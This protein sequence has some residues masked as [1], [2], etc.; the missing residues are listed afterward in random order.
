MARTI[1]QKA[2]EKQSMWRA[3][4]L[5][6]AMHK[7]NRPVEALLN[8]TYGILNSV[9]SA[10]GKKLASLSEYIDKED[11]ELDNTYYNRLKRTYVTPYL[12]NAIDSA[13]GILFR[14]PPSVNQEAKMD[15]RVKEII[16]DDVNLEGNDLIEFGIMAQQM[17]FAYGQALVIGS[18]DNPSK[19]EN[20]K[21]QEDSGARP[22]LKLISPQDLLGFSVDNQ[23]RPVMIRYREN[24]R[25]VDNENAFYGESEVEQ[26]TVITPTE[27]R[28]FRK[29]E[30]GSEFEAERGEIV[31][32]DMDTSQRITD[33][34][35]LKVLYGRKINTLRAAPVFEDLAHAN[36]QHVQVN[37]DLSWNNH[38]S[39]IPFLFAELS[40][41]VDPKDFNIGTLSSSVQVKLPTG[42][43]IKWIETTGVPQTQGRQFLKDIENR[44][45]ITTM[46]TDTG[47]SG[48]RETATGRAIDANH[49]S[50][51]LRAHSEALESWLTECVDMLHTFYPNIERGLSYRFETNKDFEITIENETLAQ[52]TQDVVAGRITV[53]RYLV[54][55]KR[56]GV[57]SE[58]FNV[59]EELKKLDMNGDSAVKTADA[60]QTPSS[61]DQEQIE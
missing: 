8:G 7:R 25:V 18:F 39:L 13:T 54:E 19:S 33:R 56:R 3:T 6:Q 26:I 4:N 53:E 11:G 32:Y 51:K 46:S 24:V 17:A 27:Y 23:N 58:D 31:R 15:L 2:N 36:I 47:V 48:T 21:E 22:F 49:T 57:Y 59:Q 43:N 45:A 10:T 9:D 16:D 30:K 14:V 41:E 55:L 50:S 12:S 60:E 1:Q 38:F 42:S 37:S 29:D 5:C 44:M 40:S 35:P 61:P 34:L 52:L 20:L 28:C